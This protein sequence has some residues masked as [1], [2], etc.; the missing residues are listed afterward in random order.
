MA[1]VN[2][3]PDRVSEKGAHFH[4]QAAS[5]ILIMRESASESVDTHVKWGSRER[6]TLL[7]VSHTRELQPHYNQLRKEEELRYTSL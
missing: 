4:L 6:R 2:W 5:P 1:V 3:E 7:C